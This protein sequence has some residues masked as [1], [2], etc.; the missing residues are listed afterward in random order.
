MG[1]TRPPWTMLKETAQLANDGFPNGLDLLM[2]CPVKSS[3]TCCHFKRSPFIG[4][5]SLAACVQIHIKFKSSPNPHQ[6]SQPPKATS[7]Q[8]RAVRYKLSALVW[9]EPYVRSDPTIVGLF[10][11][12]TPTQTH[13]GRCSV[14]SSFIFEWITELESTHNKLMR[15]PPDRAYLSATECLLGRRPDAMM[16]QVHPS[17]IFHYPSQQMWGETVC[18]CHRLWGAKCIFSKITLYIQEMI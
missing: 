8:K 10:A 18:F 11:Q 16:N 13:Q 17:E 2:L 3:N 14:Y 7:A 5:H 15:C 9:S 12:K 4:C 6:V 1:L